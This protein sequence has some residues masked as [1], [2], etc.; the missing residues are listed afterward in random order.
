MEPFLG[1]L[2]KRAR[3]ESAPVAGKRR[4]KAVPGVR[5][6]EEAR[7]LLEKQLHSRYWWVFNACRIKGFIQAKGRDEAD[8]GEKA[9]T[10]ETAAS[11][12]D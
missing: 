10:E 7:A 9:Q 3:G 2:M 4:G 6:V 11:V 8:G 5:E 12:E 1:D